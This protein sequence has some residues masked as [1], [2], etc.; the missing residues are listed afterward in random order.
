M[1]LYFLDL[2]NDGRITE[3]LEGTE[4]ESDQQARAE[5]EAAPRN[6]YRLPA[7]QW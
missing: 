1:T 4:C 7:A 5:A 2:R 3:D 6:G